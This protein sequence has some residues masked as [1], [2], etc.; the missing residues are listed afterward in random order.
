MV[1]RLTNAQLELAD[2]NRQIATEQRILDNIPTQSE[3]SQYQRRIV[4]LYNQSLWFEQM[5]AFQNCSIER[6]R[7]I[8]R[9]DYGGNFL[10][11]WTLLASIRYSNLLVGFSLCFCSK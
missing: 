10:M 4:E 3:I 7:I 11:K 6:Q 2:L 5:L 9:K 8:V 1:Q